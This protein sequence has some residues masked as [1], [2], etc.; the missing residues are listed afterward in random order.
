MFNITDSVNIW[1]SPKAPEGGSGSVELPFSSIDQAIE[2]A[3]AGSRVVLMPG[4]YEDKVSLREVQG[5]EMEPI[6]IMALPDRDEPVVCESEWFLYDV[7]DLIISGIT[8]SKIDN[9]AL[10]IMGTSERNIIKN[11]LVIRH[12]WP[13]LQTSPCSL[14]GGG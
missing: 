11:C 8:F 6:T 2:K 9:S 3:V 12:R 1:V 7:S 5:T 10:S 4:V 13:S 14:S